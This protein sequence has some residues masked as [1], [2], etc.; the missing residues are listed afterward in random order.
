MRLARLIAV[1]GLPALLALGACVSV[2]ANDYSW[3]PERAVIGDFGEATLVVC[4]CRGTRPA[5]TS[6]PRS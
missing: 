3:K 1:T 5:L 4:C 6:R 2:T